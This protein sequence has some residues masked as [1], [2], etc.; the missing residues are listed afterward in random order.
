MISS[1]VPPPSRQK[2][3]TY[4]SRFRV[5]RWPVIGIGL[6]LLGTIA[7]WVLLGWTVLTALKIIP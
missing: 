3:A 7:W 2:L 4:L 5:L 6:G 1:E